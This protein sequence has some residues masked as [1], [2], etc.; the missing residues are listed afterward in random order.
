MSSEIETTNSVYR[1]GAA[2]ARVQPEGRRHRRVQWTHNVLYW[3]GQVR[4][5]DFPQAVDPL[6]NPSAYQ[7]FRRDIQRLCQYFARYGIHPQPAELADRLWATSMPGDGADIQRELLA[8][9]NTAPTHHGHPGR[10]A[11]IV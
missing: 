3:E 2:R 5:I 11:D 6:Y 8:R 7:F 9:V 4:I 10:I 1:P